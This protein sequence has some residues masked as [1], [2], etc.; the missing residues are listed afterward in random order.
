M[1]RGAS[2]LGLLDH[3]VEL[4]VEVFRFDISQIGRL[5]A[6]FPKERHII[7]HIDTER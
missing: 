6:Q 5:G 7:Q 3:L 1:G 4:L 2:L